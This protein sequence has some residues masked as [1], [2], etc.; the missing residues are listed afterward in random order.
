MAVV[1][2]TLTI[3]AVIAGYIYASLYTSPPMERRLSLSFVAED[4]AIPSV[5]EMGL[6]ILCPSKAR[7]MGLCNMEERQLHAK[8]VLTVSLPPIARNPTVTCKVILVPEEMK[9]PKEPSMAW[10]EVP[11]IGKSSDFTCTHARIGESKFEFDLV[12]IGDPDDVELTTRY[13]LFVT[14]DYDEPLLSWMPLF[15][16]KVSGVGIG[17]LCL[18]GFHVGRHPPAGTRESENPLG[19]F[20]GCGV[21]VFWQR[22]MLGLEPSCEISACQWVGA[23]AGMLSYVTVHV[24]DAYDKPIQNVTVWLNTTFCCWIDGTS[25][26]LMWTGQN[27]SETSD[28]DGNARFAWVIPYARYTVMIDGVVLSEVTGPPPTV[29]TTITVILT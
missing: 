5:P 23:E 16:R 14:V 15:T 11:T 10:R 12:F 28:S 1:A 2:V 22:Q 4:H 19:K 26:T 24:V 9:P 7:E 29:S 17:D 21:A 27:F 20:G 13:M 3:S 8:Y 25:R 18:L 6:M